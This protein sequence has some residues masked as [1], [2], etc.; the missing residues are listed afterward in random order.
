MELFFSFLLD[1]T[2]LPFTLY[3]D[4]LS[5]SQLGDSDF[6]FMVVWGWGVK[7]ESSY[8]WLAPRPDVV[9][10]IFW[11][12]RWVKEE[13]RNPLRTERCEEWGVFHRNQNLFLSFASSKKFKVKSCDSFYSLQA[14]FLC[15]FVFLWT[16]NYRYLVCVG[17]KTDSYPTTY[18]HTCLSMVLNS[19]GLVLLKKI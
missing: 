3:F 8:W 10:V 11:G 6:Q 15:L 14:T 2:S 4:P 1:Q 12:T 5:H 18:I 17:M 9:M 16:F 7:L 13:S 19:T